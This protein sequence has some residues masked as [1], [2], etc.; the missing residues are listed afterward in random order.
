ME[1]AAGSGPCFEAKYALGEWN[2]MN[3]GSEARLLTL[4]RHVAYGNGGDEHASK[5]LDE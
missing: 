3:P 5:S 1:S 4:S 2:G